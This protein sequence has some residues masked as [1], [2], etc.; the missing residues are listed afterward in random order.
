MS[1]CWKE[2]CPATTEKATEA[3]LD[4]SDYLAIPWCCSPRCCQD[5][6]ARVLQQAITSP[7]YNVEQ[8]EKAVIHH[9]QLVCVPKF[10]AKCW[11][12]NKMRKD[13][14]LP[15]E[16]DV[17]V[18][19]DR[20]RLPLDGSLINIDGP[21]SLLT[22]QIRAG[23][24]LESSTFNPK[25]QYLL[26]KR[27]LFRFLRKQLTPDEND[28]GY[29]GPG[30]EEWPALSAKSGSSIPPLIP[31]FKLS[32]AAID[33]T[34]SISGSNPAFAMLQPSDAAGSSSSSSM[35][36]EIAAV[37]EGFARCWLR[38]TNP[39]DLPT[40]QEIFKRSMPEQAVAEIWNCHNAQSARLSKVR[41]ELKD[42]FNDSIDFKYGSAT[43]GFK[44]LHGNVTKELVL[45]ETEV[46]KWKDRTLSE[47]KQQIKDGSK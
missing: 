8:Y 11:M 40:T 17:G 10:A 31:T 23:G 9:C 4:S 5:D 37:E 3:T 35:S 7:A 26:I 22:D 2:D 41:Q 42:V 14:S 25:Q 30:D 39:L 15:L 13:M 1:S 38:A 27:E 47:V 36:I 19:V 29:A 12:N 45:K 32:T 46:Q 24:K 34:S 21:R 43:E 28:I 16:S 6:L 44:K 18:F 20:Q 33:R